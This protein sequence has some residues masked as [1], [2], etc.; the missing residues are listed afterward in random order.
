MTK[1]DVK[2]EALALGYDARYSGRKKQWFFKHIKGVQRKTGIN[3][4]KKRISG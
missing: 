4:L 1:E 3:A 2:A